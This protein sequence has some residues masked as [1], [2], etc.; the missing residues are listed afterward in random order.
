MLDH[1]FD[2]AAGLRRLVQPRPV[3]LWPLALLPGASARWIPWLAQGLCEL[4]RNPVVVDATCGQAATAFGFGA[5]ARGDLLDLLEGRAGFDGVARRSRK[6]VHVLRGDKGI[7]AFAG[8]GAPAERLLAAFGA[9]SHGFTDLLVAM[10]GPEIAC[11]AA[12]AAH[13]P[14]LTIELSGRGV[15]DGYALVKRLA[16]EFR[17]RRFACVVTGAQSEEQARAGFGRVH[18][19]ARQF[20]GAEASWAGWLPPPTDERGAAEASRTA[21]AL[22]HLDTPAALAA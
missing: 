11:I 8:S 10:P 22:L 3:R 4:G 12:P 13:V 1:G 18:G 2:Q 20:L 21:D 19:A 14:V 6:G 5:P 16:S 7:E 9:L 15:M 17:Y